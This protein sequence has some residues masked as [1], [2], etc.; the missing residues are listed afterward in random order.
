MSAE[1]DPGTLAKLIGGATA[2]GAAALSFLFQRVIRKHDEEIA[3]IKKDIGEVEAK[4]GAKADNTEL[5]RQRDHIEELFQQS[6]TDKE[7][8][9]KAIHQLSNSIITGLGERP[10]RTEVMTL[11]QQQAR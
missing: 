2:I 5:T 3:T 1:A 9:L 10:T 6:R 4:L 11:L 7:E 8:I